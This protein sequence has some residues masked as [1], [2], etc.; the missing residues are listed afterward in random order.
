[1]SF[2][3][4]CVSGSII[5]SDPIFTKAELMKESKW[6]LNHYI[7]ARSGRWSSVMVCGKIK[8]RGMCVKEVIHSSLDWTDGETEETKIVD[9][10][11]DSGCIVIMDAEYYPEDTKDHI[12]LCN[13]CYRI[14]RYDF[15]NLVSSRGFVSRSGIGADH[16]TSKMYFD[17]HNKV[18]K[19]HICFVK[20][21][22]P[23]MEELKI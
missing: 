22:L 12:D 4:N 21:V 16:Y 6:S 17:K 9:I 18:G 11:V 1:M 19:I 20:R 7:N 14:V 15:G 8:D 5:I 2:Q 13:K 10:C 23:A 3:W